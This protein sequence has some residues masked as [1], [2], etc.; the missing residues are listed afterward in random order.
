MASEVCSALQCISNL[1]SLQYRPVDP[2]AVTVLQSVLQECRDPHVD[3]L[4]EV[5]YGVAAVSRLLTAVHHKPL[6]S[7]VCLPDGLQLPH[8]HAGVV[9]D[10]QLEG[11]LDVAADGGAGEK[12]EHRV[13]VVQRHRD[14]VAGVVAAQHLITE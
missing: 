6:H 8:A 3:V 4:E 12:A 5:E 1:P 7:A 10:E 9:L 2:P 11:E 14:Q 13:Q